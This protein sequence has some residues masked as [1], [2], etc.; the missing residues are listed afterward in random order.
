MSVKVLGRDNYNEI[1]E[2]S[3]KPVLVDFYADWCGPCRMV[4]PI[5]DEIGE[6]RDDIVVCKVNVD[7]EPEL[8]RRFGIVSIPTL[9]VLKS[10]EVVNKSVGAKPKEKIL[11]L[12]NA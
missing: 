12:V 10:G 2:N 6:E 3:A 8:S 1:V 4:S 7:R 5:V 11:E 9:I